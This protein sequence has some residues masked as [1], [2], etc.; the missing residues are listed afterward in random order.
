MAELRKVAGYSQHELAAEVGFS[1][2]MVVYYERETDYPPAGI[3]PELAR[4]LGVTTDHLLGIK[5]V[6]SRT[7]K[8]QDT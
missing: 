3:R 4:V 7:K 5:P 1:Q 8:P 2:R 6:R